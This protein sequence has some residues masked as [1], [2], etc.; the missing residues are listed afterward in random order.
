MFY[1][2]GLSQRRDEFNQALRTIMECC[3]PGFTGDNLI[4]LQ[5]AAGF[6]EDE[7]FMQCLQKLVENKQERSLSWRLHTL[8]WA[9]Q[10]AL[11]LDGDFV[12]CGVHRAFCS[13]FICDYLD[14]A[15]V[16]KTFYLYDTFAGIP[17]HL[18]S[19]KRSNDAYYR[20]N[21]VDPNAIYKAAIVRLIDVPNAH[22]V[23][24]VIPDSFAV[25]CP[26]KIA[27]LHVD[28]NAAAAE[29][30][31]LEVLFDRV[32]LGGMIVFDD[33][34]WSGYQAQR[35]AE[36]AFMAER[37]HHILELPTGQGLLIKHA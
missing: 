13:S 27:F 4:A 8:I 18:N 17:E 16:D 26:Q 29:I 19:E 20:E 9:A 34:G 24:G 30:A 15:S 12:E 7:K 35:L 37:G 10:T 36:D 6:R 5:R 21:S 14:F 11:R 28:L 33:Y 23:R 31:A 22:F 2:V 3:G 1:G 25:A 32:V